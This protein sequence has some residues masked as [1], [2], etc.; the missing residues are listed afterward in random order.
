[1]PAMDSRGAGEYQ[2]PSALSRLIGWTLARDWTPPTYSRLGAAT[3]SWPACSR[4]T[5]L[6]FLCLGLVSVG[7]VIRYETHRSGGIAYSSSAAAGAAG[8]VTQQS[9]QKVWP[10][11]GPGLHRPALRATTPQEPQPQSPWSLVT[12]AEGA[13]SGFLGQAALS[14]HLATS[15]ATVTATTSTTTATVTATTTTSTSVTTTTYTTTTTKL[16]SVFGFMV[17]RSEGYEPAL[18]QQQFWKKASIFE[19]EEYAVYSNGGPVKIGP[20]D[21]VEIPAPEVEMGNMSKA[22]TTTSSWLNTVI[23]MKAW[24]LVLSDSKWWRHEWTV[25]V[26]PDAVFFPHRLK[27]ALYSYYP[28]GVIEGPALFMANCDR[29]WNGEPW[30]L[31][32]FGSLEVYSRNALGIYKAKGADCKKD[33][34]WEGWGEDFF[35]QNCMEKLQVGV[36][37]GVKYLG[38]NR[39]YGA[40]CT[41]VTKV[42]FH[43]FKDPGAY[44]ACWGASKAAEGAVLFKK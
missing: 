3:R 17:V 8:A 4:G 7:V 33:L 22:G 24:D 43:D 30:K 23:F 1:M 40:P 38:D 31:K 20:I 10:P 36:I 27:V 13:I 42:A 11:E 29:S 14:L 32:L 28:A 35:M 5:R 19:C 9:E 16:T 2:H 26:D 37:N 12:G 34:D 39:C 44:M 15:T 6:A 25:K 21:A 18:V 41:D